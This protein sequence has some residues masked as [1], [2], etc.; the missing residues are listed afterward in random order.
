MDRYFKQKKGLLEQRN[1][2][3][4]SQFAWSAKFKPCIYK[5][6]LLEVFK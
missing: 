5:S 1:I 3:F 6:K 2:K 4:V